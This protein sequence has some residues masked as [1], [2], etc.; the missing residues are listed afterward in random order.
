MFQPLLGALIFGAA[1]AYFLWLNRGE[2]RKKRLFYLA[3]WYCTALATL[4][5]GAPGLLLPVV[6]VGAVLVARRD[7]LEL[8]RIELAGFGLLFAAVCLPWYVQAYMRHGDQFTDRLLM[9]DM[10][11][12][13]FVHVHDTN[14]G[15]DVSLRYYVWQLGYGLFPWTGLARS[16]SVWRWRAAARTASCAIWRPSSRCGS[17]SDLRCSRCR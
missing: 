2:R 1:L 12:R 16:A 17:P 11:K 8:T 3:A 6:I 7:W 5:K 13:A 10:Y 4:A 14:T 9:H 15:S